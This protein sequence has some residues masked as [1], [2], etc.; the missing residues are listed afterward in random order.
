MDLAGVFKIK[1]DGH[2]NAQHDSDGAANALDLRVRQIPQP[3][4]DL[5]AAYGADLAFGGNSRVAMGTEFHVAVFHG[6]DLLSRR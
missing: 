5:F 3:R 1:H 2:H 6:S 4:A